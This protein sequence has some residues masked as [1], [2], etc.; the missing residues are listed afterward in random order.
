MSVNTAT[1]APDAP[2]GCYLL[3]LINHAEAL[4]WQDRAADVAACFFAL[5]RKEN[6]GFGNDACSDSYRARDPAAAP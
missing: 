5:R 6:R 1:N 4:S 3:F 2:P